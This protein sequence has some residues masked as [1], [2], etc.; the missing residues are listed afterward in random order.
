MIVKHLTHSIVGTSDPLI[1]QGTSTSPFNA[2]AQVSVTD[3]GTY[4][5]EYSCDMVHWIIHPSSNYDTATK[6]F[7][8]NFPIMGVRVVTTAITG[9][10]I[11]TTIEMER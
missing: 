11:L 1:F 7:S 3:T 10:V 5:V 8:F 4:N 2:V 9:P 6:T